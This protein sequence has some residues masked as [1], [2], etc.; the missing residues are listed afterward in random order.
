MRSGSG[1]GKAAMASEEGRFYYLRLMAKPPRE[2]EPP[3]P[4]TRPKFVQWGPARRFSTSIE[5]DPDLEVPTLPLLH[6]L[7]T[8]SAALGAH[9]A[10]GHTWLHFP[11]LAPK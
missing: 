11:L 9:R 5:D 6:R 2:G 8:Q 10:M 7:C 4:I 1:S 3:E